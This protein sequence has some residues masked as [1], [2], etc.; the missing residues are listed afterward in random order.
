MT[1]KKF[2]PSKPGLYRAL[3]RNEQDKPITDSN[4][5]MTASGNCNQQLQ[6]LHDLF[7]DDMQIEVPPPLLP[8]LRTRVRLEEAEW[9]R[10]GF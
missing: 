10:L 5:G 4:W 7:L 9:V 3:R 1:T 2:V 8:V 6:Q